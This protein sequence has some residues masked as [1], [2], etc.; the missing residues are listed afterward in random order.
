MAGPSSSPVMSRL[1]APGRW[2]LR[3]HE[4]GDGALHVGGAAAEQLAVAQLGGERVGR[5]GRLVAHGNDVGVACEAEVA[6]TVA[7]DAG[8]EVVDV[9][10]VRRAECQAMAGE[11]E[12]FE[13]ILQDVERARI[14]RRDARAANQIAGQFDRID[15]DGHRSIRA[16]SPATA[17]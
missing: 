14:R 2:P 6:G 11:A 4:G 15:I 12:A 1:M 13:R 9:R 17:R 3:C 10:R 7:A 5:P 16:V 8:I